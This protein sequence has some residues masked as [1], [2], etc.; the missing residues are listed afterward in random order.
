MGVRRAGLIDVA[1]GEGLDCCASSRDVSL[2]I[3]E[4]L[5]EMTLSQRAFSS[6]SLVL[7]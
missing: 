1:A 5:V 6:W 4:V 2:D 3:R 7:G